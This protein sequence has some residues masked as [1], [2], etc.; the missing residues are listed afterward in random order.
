M[1]EWTRKSIRLANSPGYLDRLSQV[2]TMQVNPT[3][4]LSQPAT[5]LIKKAY[6][7]RDDLS[8][9]KL[10]IE[11]AAVFPVKDSYV[12]FLRK[13]PEAMRKNPNTVSRIA[14]RLYSMEFEILIR[15]ASRPKE[16]NRQLGNAFKKWLTT[17]GYKMVDERELIDSRRGIL[18]LRGSDQRLMEFSR[19]QLDCRLKKGIDLVAKKDSK[20]IVG[21]AKFLTTPGGEQD[22]GFDDALSFVGGEGGNALRIALIDGY[23]WLNNDTGLN[24]KIR[25]GNFPIMSAILVK[26][27]L[28]KLND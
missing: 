3:R 18:L 2:Y 27:F 25:S 8:L 15:E 7:K 26:N 11:H 19:R 6:V 14:E 10:L 9:V 1:N 5:A 21:E 12:G 28:S 24:Q 4:P 22:R 13:H 20:Y 16:T 17:I 23:V